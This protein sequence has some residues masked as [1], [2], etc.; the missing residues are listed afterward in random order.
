[1]SSPD[2][3]AS[4]RFQRNMERLAELMPPEQFAQLMERVEWAIDGS[5]G[6][7]S[8]EDIAAALRAGTTPGHC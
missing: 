1:M 2:E 5:L 7:A 8:D 6:G 3:T 4:Q